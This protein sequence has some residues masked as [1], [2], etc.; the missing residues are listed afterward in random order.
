MEDART[1]KCSSPPPLYPPSPSLLPPPPPPSTFPPP[2]P[3][4]ST[5]PPPPPPSQ[6]KL[7]RKYC[8]LVECHQEAGHYSDAVA[9]ISHVVTSLPANQITE[10]QHI[11]VL[12]SQFVRA[13]KHAVKAGHDD[14]TLNTRYGEG[15]G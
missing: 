2:P 6:V 4:P 10:Q 1:D 8:L 9:T 7:I 3:P 14:P 13:K 11:S 15:M 5:F 12:I